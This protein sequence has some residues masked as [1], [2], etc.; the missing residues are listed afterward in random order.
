MCGGR[1]GGWM[2]GRMEGEGCLPA[3]LRLCGGAKTSHEKVLSTPAVA[4][5]NADTSPRSCD[6]G[7]RVAG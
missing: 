4:E 3:F 2:E 5:S 1:V 7:V 6:C